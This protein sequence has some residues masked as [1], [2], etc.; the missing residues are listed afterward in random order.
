MGIT[1]KIPFYPMDGRKK[2]VFVEVGGPGLLEEMIDIFS[3]KGCML[4]YLRVDPYM[5]I[6]LL[7]W[8]VGRICR[9]C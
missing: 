3:I 5:R 7:I 6:M 4:W 9:T 2:C 1:R 8:G